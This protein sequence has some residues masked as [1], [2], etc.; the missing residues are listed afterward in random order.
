[1]NFI[2]RLQKADVSKAKKPSFGPGDT[3]KVHVRVVEGS[4][5]RI[6]V[7]EG[8][9]IARRHG[10]HEETFTVRKISAGG[11]G[12]EK[13]FPLHSPVIQKIQVVRRGAVRRN[14]LYYLRGVT[15]KRGRIAE[16]RQVEPSPSQG[17]QPA[18]TATAAAKEG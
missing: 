17:E 16:R 13:I 4:K 3:I 9:V 12:V 14:K 18:S 11:I 7:F 5:E 6:Q 8:V 1:M 10:G 15:G 2:Q